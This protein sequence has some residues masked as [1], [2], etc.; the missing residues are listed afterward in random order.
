MSDLV[1]GP[2]IGRIGGASAPLDLSPA[3]PTD[4]VA[5]ELPDG[6]WAVTVKATKEAGTGTSFIRVNGVVGAE[7]TSRGGSVAW[8]LV[9][10]VSGAAE[11]TVDDRASI[12]SVIAFPDPA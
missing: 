5:V 11:I 10:Y 4:S 7:I 1:L 2:A 6:Q 8:G 12:T 3:A 9:R